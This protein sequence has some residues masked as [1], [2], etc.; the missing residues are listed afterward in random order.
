MSDVNHNTKHFRFKFEDGEA[1]SGLNVASALITKVKKEGDEKPTIRPYTPV[2]DEDSKGYLDFVIKKYP[3]GPMSEH[4]HS[5]K[6]GQTLDMKGPIPKY[7]WATNKH[8]HIA[9][10]AGGTGIT[11]M[12]QLCR[13]I[14]N[15]PEDK[16]KV[17]MIFGNVTQDDILLK[18]ELE[19]LE[20][21]YPDRFRAFYVLDNPPADWKQGKGFITKD[22]LKTTIP[23]PQ[24]GNVKVF[25]CGPP[26]LY[27]AISGMKKSPA[28]QGELTGYL[29]ELGYGEDQVY[30]F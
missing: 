17:T 12:W 20:K 1:V 8:E 7:P 5:L 13:A 30:K 14:F 24:D 29:K 11:P 23:G 15:N 28:E 27:K 18:P 6:P 3:N 19:K 9:L 16:T 26:G 2:S 10:I 4:L 25:V 22:L 21:D